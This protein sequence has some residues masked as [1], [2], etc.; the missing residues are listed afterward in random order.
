MAAAVATG[1][2][3]P[4]AVPESPAA[5]RAVA[6]STR[7]ATC[8]G[9]CGLC[10]STAG[11]HRQG[12]ALGRG[13][14]AHV[15]GHETAQRAGHPGEQRVGGPAS[16]RQRVGEQVGGVFRLAQPA[17]HHAPDHQREALRP[18][19]PRRRRT[20]GTPGAP[21]GRRR[22][23]RPVRRWRTRRPPAGCPPPRPRRPAH[24]TAGRSGPAG[25]PPA[26]DRRAA[27]RTRWCRAA[28]PARTGPSARRRAGRPGRAPRPYRRSRPGWWSPRPGSATTTPARARSRAARLT[29]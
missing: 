2:S 18:S 27:G 7:G 4:T 3:S 19:R 8:A 23:A 22:P 17:G 1:A 11:Q 12:V 5:S 21:P 16:V 15:Q 10:G 28:T 6:S 14:V 29:W 13:P 25:A 20:P 26:A 24:R 9:A